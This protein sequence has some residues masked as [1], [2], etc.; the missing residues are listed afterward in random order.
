M[1]YHRCD[2]HSLARPHNNIDNHLYTLPELY[3]D[4]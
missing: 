2:V 4:N 1:Y 3:L